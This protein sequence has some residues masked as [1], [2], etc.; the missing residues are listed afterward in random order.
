MMP[1]I[2]FEDKLRFDAVQKLQQLQYK[3]QPV[4]FSHHHGNNKIVKAWRGVN[5][6]PSHHKMAR[7]SSAKMIFTKDTFRSTPEGGIDQGYSTERRQLPR[8]AKEEIR[9]C[10]NYLWQRNDNRI[11]FGMDF[12][13]K[14]KPLGIIDD[15]IEKARERRAFTTFPFFNP[16]PFDH[17]GVSDA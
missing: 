10:S 14:F 5:F 1:R 4:S 16:A 3:D 17:R 7:L 13:R 6:A 11:K 9:T 15:A 2:T 8:K 12:Y